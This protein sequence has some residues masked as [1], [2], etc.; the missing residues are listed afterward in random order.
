MFP[1]LRIEPYEEGKSPAHAVSFLGGND[2]EEWLFGGEKEEK[3]HVGSRGR[4]PTKIPSVYNIQELA[5]GEE[6][7][8]NGSGW[9]KKQALGCIY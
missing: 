4:Y 1:I 2:E 9:G 6:R 5:V 8:P 3:E 7:G